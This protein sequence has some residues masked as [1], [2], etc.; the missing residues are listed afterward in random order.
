[1]LRS[2]FWNLP[3]FL[4]F[5]RCPGVSKDKHSWFLGARDASRNPETIEMKVGG[6]SHKQLEKLLDQIEAE[7]FPA[8]FQL[9]IW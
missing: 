3:V 8:A 9:F 2:L 5:L 1:M 6:L 4:D 7:W